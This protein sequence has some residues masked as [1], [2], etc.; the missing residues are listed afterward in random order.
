MKKIIL[1][2]GLLIILATL[3]ACAEVDPNQAKND[4]GGKIEIDMQAMKA[5][6]TI[7]IYNE[8]KAIRLIDFVT[9]E[10]PEDYTYRVVASDG[11]SPD[12]FNYSD[13]ETGYWLL[14]TDE[15]FFPDN[16]LGSTRLREPSKI[17]PITK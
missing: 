14:E 7:T 10:N 4:L 9:L 8:E 12:P 2:L 11:Y 15:T 6:M 17:I 13:I 16:N 1:L 3:S 5:D